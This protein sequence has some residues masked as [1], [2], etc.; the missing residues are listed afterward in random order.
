[1]L[2]DFTITSLDKVSG[3]DLAT[4]EVLFIAYDMQTF[5]ISQSEDT[6]DITGKQGRRISTLKRNKAVTLS[7]THG[8]LSP[9]ILYQQTGSQFSEKKTTI[10]WD[11]T[12]T[13]ASNKVTLGYT[14]VGDLLNVY[15]LNADGS[16]GA[17]L[18][19]ATDNTVAAGKYKYDASNKQLTLNATDAPD[20]TEIYVEYN[21]QIQAYVHENPSDAYSRKCLL[22]ADV[23]CEDECGKV[24]HG[25]FKFDKADFN[26]NFS[27]DM[28]DNQTVH[29]F[30]ASS[31]VNKCENGGKL[32]HWTV[33][34]EG[35]ED[36][37]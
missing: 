26:G 6:Q 14:P 13:A 24:Y 16:M 15:T 21:R 9:G 8:L 34:G 23:T 11:D 37:A 36:V 33:F 2:K 28:G 29:S 20:G 25:Q 4:G 27:F 5:N 35:A 22:Y 31:M 18:T 32:W 17:R 3:Y 30:E 12:H 7:G 10:K 1:M 19:A